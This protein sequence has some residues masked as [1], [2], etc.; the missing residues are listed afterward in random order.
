MAELLLGI[1]IGT[2]GCKT[3]LIDKQGTYVAD[4][5]SEYVTYHPKSNWSEQ[6]AADWFPAFLKALKSAEQKSGADRRDIIGISVSASS[7]NAVLLDDHGEVLRDTIMWTDQRSHK[8]SEYLKQ[9][10]G[11]RIFEI[12]YQIPAP[13]WTQ[14]QLLWLRRNE[15][16]VFGK[17]YKI[18]FIKDFVRYQLTGVW[19]TDYIEAQ[20]SL[21]FD[22]LR[23]AWSEELCA[24]IE[25]RPE[26]LPPIV[27]PSDIVGRVTAEAARRTGL[28]EGIPVVN[29]ASDTAL[30]HYCV[31]GIHEGDCVVKIATASTVDIFRN[32]PAPHQ[33]ALTYS[34]VP[35]GIWSTCFATSSAAASLRWYRDTF[36]SKE[37]LEE[38]QG[39][40][41]VYQTLD[42]EAAAV[43]PGA[44]GLF[45]HPYLMGERSPYWDPKLRGSFVGITASHTRGHFNRAILEGVGYSIKENF[46]I[47]EQL[48]PIQEVRLVGGGAKSGLWADITCNMLN[49]PIIRFEKDDSSFGAAMLAGVGIGVFASHEK[50]I[51]LC[52]KERC[53]VYPDQS[54]VQL[55]DEEFSRYRQI[56]EDLKNVYD[57]ER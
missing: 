35:K 51:A 27:S 47:A 33:A 5:F 2:G 56:H 44:G 39:G 22:N 6:K 15:P 18:M 32:R 49:R 1:D 17:I 28:L 38:E 14:P 43:K 41:N 10:F 9:T 50:A 34:Q 57:M 13:T 21:L 55:Y 46:S 37:M 40:G 11:K 24:M 16:E 7:H 48:Q 23:W 3:T 25:L 20:G 30:E 4:G 54:I 52:A 53:R 26:V 29:G 42:V 31:G 12:G 36:C 45:F 19:C 8:E